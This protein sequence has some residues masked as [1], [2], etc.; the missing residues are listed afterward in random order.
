MFHRDVRGKRVLGLV[1]ISAARTRVPDFVQDVRVAKVSL[2]VATLLDQSAA[3][4]AKEAA[5]SSH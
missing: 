2:D 4:S 5:G 3:Q 1:D